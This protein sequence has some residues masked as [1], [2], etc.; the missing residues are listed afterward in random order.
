MKKQI[1]GICL[2]F[3]FLES[4]KAQMNI[5]NNQNCSYPMQMANSMV[6]EDDGSQEE[7]KELREQ[8]KE[9][10]NEKKRLEKL[11]AERTTE[12]RQELQ[13]R[14]KAEEKNEANGE[15]GQRRTDAVMF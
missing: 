8:L 13:E 2:F 14:K 4:A 1:V 11:V 3:A 10:K 12:L 7:I 9:K 5:L 6:E 15:D